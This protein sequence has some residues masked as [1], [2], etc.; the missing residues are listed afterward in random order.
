MAAP[1]KPTVLTPKVPRAS[2]AKAKP[3]PED[4][5]PPWAPRAG[6]EYRVR[7]TEESPFGGFER[8]LYTGDLFDAEIRHAEHE[9]AGV[10]SVIE[11]A[12][13]YGYGP[14][15]R[16][17]VTVEALATLGLAR[18]V[19]GSK[20]SISPEGQRRIFESMGL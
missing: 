2:R 5:R 8:P 9:A 4:A 11:H 12:D 14:P 10:R 3:A 7:I 15:P 17:V 19:G 13:R 20:W 6:R 18:E 16:E 1:R